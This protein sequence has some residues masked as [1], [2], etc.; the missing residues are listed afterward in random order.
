[1]ENV[2]V[3]YA[4]DADGTG[5]GGGQVGSIQTTF[6]SIDAD[7]RTRLSNV[8]ITDGYSNGVNVLSGNPILDQVAVQDSRGVPAFFDIDASPSVTRLTGSG[9]AGGDHI[10]L[11]GGTLTEDRA[12]D[13]GELPLVMLGDV[14]VN[15]D[16]QAQP[17][18][19]SLAPGTVVKVPNG[20]YLWA[21]EGMISAIG[22]PAEPIV[23]TATSDDSIGGDSNGDGNATSPYRGWWESIYLDTPGNVL[24]NVE[25]RYAGDTDGNGTGGGQTGSIELRYDSRDPS[26]QNRLTNVRVSSGYGN[27]V[28]VRA[29]A[30]VLENVHAEKMA[31]VPFYFEF[32]SN[33]TTVGLTGRDNLGG[34]QISL[35]VGVLKEDRVWD[36]GDLPLHL[37]GDLRV[38]QDASSR[39]ATLTIA[40]GTVVKV[41][42]ARYLWA[43]TGTIHAVG[44][45]AEP[46]V[47]TAATDD[48]VGGDSNG[49]ASATEPFRG[50]WESIY[51]NGPN[52]VLRNVEI[53]YAGDTD[54]NGIG[55]GQVA[56]VSIDYPGSVATEQ[57]QLINV[58]ISD[59]YSNAVNVL[60]GDAI[61]QN[62]HAEDNDGVPFYF[63][64]V[65]DPQTSGLSARNNLGGDRIDIQA[66]TLTEDRHW[67]YGD[68]PIHLINGSFTVRTDAL[69]NPAVLTIAPGTTVKLEPAQ[70]LQA[71]T[72]TINAIGTPEKPI[73]FTAASDD[74]FGGDSNGDGN[75]TS[76]FP[77]YWES[78][79][80]SGPDNVLEHVRVRYAGDTDGNG[81]GGGQVGSIEVR[82]SN[83]NNGDQARLSNVTVTDGYSNG[84][85]VFSG[86]PALDR[87]DV[88]DN[89]GAAYFFD[90]SSN[91]SISNL[92]G[93]DNLGGDRIAINGGT[94]TANRTWN[95]GPL[96]IH[97]FGG[98]LVV[99]DDVDGNPVTLDIAAGTTVK[100]DAAFYLWAKE[101]S[102][103]ANGTEENPIYFTA[104]SDDTV[105]G[106]ATGDG[107]LTKPYPGFW[108]AIYIDRDGS[109]LSNVTI[110]YSGDADGNGFGGGD[111]AAIDL[112]A[113]ATLVNV[114]VESAYGGALR[115]GS[116]ASVTYSGG[117]LD[118]TTESAQARAAILVAQGSLNATDLDIIGHDGTGDVGVVVSNGQFAS[119][120]NSSFWK[121]ALAVR[122][123]G[124]DPGKAVF[125][126]NWWSSPLGPHDPS[127]A[128]G[129]VNDNPA[130]QRVSDYVDY[131]NFLT[132]PPARSLGPRVIAFESL[133]PV[134]PPIHHRFEA[135]GARY[136]E[137]GTLQGTAIGDASYA[138]GRTGGLAFS[139]DGNDAINLGGLTLKNE[140]TV[141]AW[142]N[143]SVVPATGRVTI[144]GADSSG[145]D[146][147]IGLLDGRFVAHYKNG[148][149]LDSG[150][151]AST[152]VWTHVA[153]TLR[154]S[155]LSLYIDG[156]VRA[157]V[158]I[159]DAYIPATTGLRIGST[160]FNN[161]GFFTGLIDE[162]SIVER[163]V[164]D[165]E[166]STLRDSGTIDALPKRDR[167]L[168]V[169]DRLLDAASVER[170]DVTL[171]GPTAVTVDSVEVIGD[172]SLIVT[173]T[174]QLSNAGSYTFS[175]GPAIAG[176]SG[177]FMDQDADG[178]AGEAVDDVF[179]T[180]LIVDRIGPR[181]I[182]QVPDGTTDQVLTAFEVTFNEAIDPDR[183]PA[184]S[185]RLLTPSMI[186]ERD[187]FDPSQTTDGF[188]V[189]GVRSITSFD[190]VEFAERILQDSALVT[191][192]ETGEFPVI[193]FGPA[194]VSF[195]N[196]F[197]L[198]LDRPENDD[199]LAWEAQGTVTIPTP[200]KRTFAISSDDGYRLEIGS[201]A[202]EFP[203][204]R[205]IATDLVTFDFS[206]AGDFP[207][208]FVFFELIGTC[209]FELS[210]APG[211]KSAFDA[212]F[213]LVGDTASGG[214]AVRHPRLPPND[215]IS[216]LSVVP[217]DSGNTTF[218]VTF[219]PQPLDGQYELQIDPDVT[220]RQGNPLDQDNDGVGGNRVTT[221]TFVA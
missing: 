69:G 134:D 14:I 118:R 145:R 101:G 156:V 110:R 87:V 140:W 161:A 45:P 164:S 179:V 25:V 73:V 142:V 172:R 171:S 126:N 53:R 79:Y 42:P 221:A 18:T 99:S 198:P 128:D 41:A 48:T 100:M 163:G 192:V 133:G 93:E 56:A 183:F 177:F 137:S 80:L 95:Y 180:S 9:N 96:P 115:V 178:T 146:W 61:L 49:D 58:R 132:T 20:R 213:K 62:V 34:D 174:G 135:E 209:G 67:N 57:P 121:N 185:A 217:I 176:S 186:A 212:D 84:I 38:T 214:L 33:P 129:V 109:S 197:K 194:G 210:S 206:E 52:N 144:V 165:T 55:G 193:N 76:P 138:P 36:Y 114:N 83:V 64:L 102:I 91:P 92:T 19:L 72:G 35:E 187:A 12:W 27:G 211:E 205:G 155:L 123:D 3:R 152:H 5:S 199:Y 68:L 7:A 159:G 188:V 66:G 59:G 117:R 75:A 71:D 220:D 148:Q 15:R 136:D 106:D 98:N 158:D 181:I 151:T 112:D 154:G 107:D 169:F 86:T 31:G 173:L 141:A 184:A 22:T 207:I 104:V 201:M 125:R 108:E 39:P 216:A 65:T 24:E 113:S 13:Y 47:V 21:R 63:A 150:V 175:V 218:R 208:R 78:L 139:L 6:G 147:S 82:Q 11:Q 8:L 127:A 219:P 10:A 111:V 88:R 40:P 26:L 124:T 196:N 85:N 120:A 157:S 189:R 50:F 90:L 119:L 4:G 17:V 70:W 43:D 190:R 162:V 23:L 204:G 1:M 44:T 182:S 200:G 29:G 28:N 89:L 166:I 60:R 191:E 97:I 103:Q 167:F 94:L 160:A 131:S 77:G 170:G 16:A 51:L 130:G 143:P 195:G 116:N 30:P 105:G 37:I 46:I 153:A 32:D 149:V 81:T 122:H 74:A 202:A 215:S 203:T 54:G 2:Q 168:V